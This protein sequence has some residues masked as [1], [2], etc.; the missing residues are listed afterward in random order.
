MD[1]AVASIS[2]EGITIGEPRRPQA[3]TGGSGPWRT[4]IAEF[5]RR[6]RTAALRVR[7]ICGE[8]LVAVWFSGGAE[9]REPTA[10]GSSVHLDVLCLCDTTPGVPV[11]TALLWNEHEHSPSAEA[12][13]DSSR[14]PGRGLGILSAPFFLARL[15]E[16]TDRALRFDRP[17]SLLILAERVGETDLPRT[18]ALIRSALR[19]TD[20]IGTVDRGALV[21]LQPETGID[22][23]CGVAERLWRSTGSGAAGVRGE[24]RWG[25]GVSSLL[26]ARDGVELLVQARAALT[27]A[28]RRDPPQV[29]RYLD[30]RVAAQPGDP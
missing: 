30:L 15:A 12:E 5:R 4:A 8:G 10:H 25:I 13:I 26:T 6:Y 1:A 24:P 22:A 23:A 27:L 11:M 18:A 7:N 29:V 9:L 3:L 21:I 16:E 28:E 17:L 19:L 2:G 20:V 14:P